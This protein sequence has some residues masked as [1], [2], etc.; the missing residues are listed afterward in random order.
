[1][2]GWR[3]LLATG[4]FLCGLFLQAQERETYNPEDRRVEIL[5]A[6]RLRQAKELG[7]DT[8]KL[9]GNVRLKH[10]EVYMRCDSA[11]LY[12]EANIVHAFSRVHLQQGDTLH[13]KGDLLRYYG[14]KD[15]AEIRDNVELIDKES[16]LYTHYL[17]YNILTETG[18]Y[19]NTGYIINGDN[20][21]DSER[22]YYYTN[23]KL[24]EFKDSV[25]LTTPDYRI[26]SDTLR[27]HTA[28][29]IAWFDGPTHMEG[30]SSQMYCEEGRYIT[31]T[32]ETWLNNNAWIFSKSQQIY[33]DALYYNDSLGLG[34]SSLRVRIVDT[35]DHIV[36]E[37]N[38]SWYR[39]NPEWFVVTDSSLFMQ[40]SGKDTLYLHAD[41]L[42]AESRTDSLTDY[43]LLR[44]YHNVK[45]YKEDFQSTCDSLSYS[46]RDSVIR[47]YQE[48]VLWTG[49][50]QITADSIALFTKSRKLD[51]ME[52]YNSAFIISQQD[53]L[54]FNQVKG[55]NMFGFFQ[56]G[57]LKRV[58]VKGNAENIYFVVEEDKLV[59]VNQSNSSDLILYMKEG[60][61]ARINMVSSVDG[62]MDPPLKNRPEEKRLNEFNWLEAIRPK[63]YRDIFR[64]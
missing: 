44:A 22:A 16:H 28:E 37:G 2:L 17:D 6:D 39:K 18:Y 13:L 12:E 9:V 25:V 26:T 1:M 23:Q 45:M 55:R 33:G 15:L 34:K 64:K 43:R 3:L 46:F 36:V 40:A 52:M 32:R 41:T 47:L 48:P 38:R 61:L 53:S 27:Y 11:Y 29:E 20:R 21:L 63:H 7:P 57:E 56:E 8:K 50:H 42:Q 5:H 51:Y 10:K 58:D 19:Y 35:T 14:N 30:D 54:R 4:I 62:V 24:A 60:K 31:K 49:V 59:G